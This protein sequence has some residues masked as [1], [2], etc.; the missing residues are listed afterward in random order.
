MFSVVFSVLYAGKT[1]ARIPHIGG[2]FSPE[3]L[4]QSD[5]WPALKFMQDQGRVFCSI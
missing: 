2:L 4:S 3:Q 1:I 5:A